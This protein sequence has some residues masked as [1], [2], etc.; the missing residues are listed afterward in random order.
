MLWAFPVGV[1]S[2]TRKEKKF[3]SF[4]RVDVGRA[5]IL[6]SRREGMVIAAQEAFSLIDIREIYEQEEA[7]HER[8]G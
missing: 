8:N 7:E 1:D 3:E 4:C 5:C 6:L 2:G